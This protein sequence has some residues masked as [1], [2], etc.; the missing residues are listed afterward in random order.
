M[1]KHRHLL[2]SFRPAPHKRRDLFIG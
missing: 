1:L 2:C